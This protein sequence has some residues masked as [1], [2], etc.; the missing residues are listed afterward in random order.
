[1]NSWKSL[2]LLLIVLFLSARGL[3]DDYQIV[4]S[5]SLDVGPDRT[6]DSIGFCYGYAATALIQNLYC[7]TKPGGC[8]YQ[9]TDELKSNDS[10]SL[11]SVRDD[12]LSVLDAISIG[13]GGVLKEIGYSSD[14]LNG[15]AKTGSLAKESCAPA[16]DLDELDE[17]WAKLAK[18]YQQYHSA[19]SQTALD[20]NCSRGVTEE[21]NSL[22]K[23]HDSNSQIQDALTSASFGEFVKKLK[24]P[25]ICEET[26]LPLPKFTVQTFKGNNPKEIKEKLLEKLRAG[27]PVAVNICFYAGASCS[28]HVVVIQ[29]FK[30]ECCEKDVCVVGVKGDCWI[31]F[32]MFD[33]VARQ[34]EP[35]PHHYYYPE[36]A[37]MEQI[38]T[39]MK[40]GHFRE[41]PLTW[42]EHQ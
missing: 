35:D 21:V 5:K 42:I 38:V 40:T 34:F 39:G 20:C 10:V 27:T 29:G 37:L 13:N 1:M 16:D 28:P 30:K 22:L 18:L 23:L 4:E 24:I 17:N 36:D 25:K 19:P 33:S 31:D 2:S 32:E 3:C 12:R 26:R 15:V 6:Q 11:T 8:K 9:I 7:K 14:V 41:E